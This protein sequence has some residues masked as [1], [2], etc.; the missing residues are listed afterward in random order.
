[1]LKTG[2][3]FDFANKEKI[4]NLLLFETTKTNKDELI[5]FKEYILRMQSDQNEVYYVFGSSKETLINNPNLEYFKKND[6]E[7]ILF[8]DPVDVFCIPYIDSFETKKLISIDKA[9]IK[10]NDNKNS[11]SDDD[12][13]FIALMKETLKD[14]VEDVIISK[15]LVSS[16]VTLIVGKT[17]MDPQMEKMMQLM[18][19]NFQASKRN[20]EV[21]TEHQLIKNLVSMYKVDKNNPKL[22]DAIIQL[23]DGAALIEGQ[24]KDVNEFIK[25]MFEFMTDATTK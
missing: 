20:L 8:T 7:V 24:I 4:V 11:S 23:F 6:I 2:L 16:P 19:K 18:D 13:E 25:R 9:E 17:G 10:E 3:N 21:N 22:S 15:R 1:M 12:N 5:S 14:K